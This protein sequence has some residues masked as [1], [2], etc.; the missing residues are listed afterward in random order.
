MNI[1]LKNP[2]TAKLYFTNI[3]SPTAMGDLGRLFRF[4][5]ERRLNSVSGVHFCW[6]FYFRAERSINTQIRQNTGEIPN[7]LEGVSEHFISEWKIITPK[8]NNVNIH[9]NLNTNDT[10][11]LFQRW[12]NYQHNRQQVQHWRQHRHFNQWNKYSLAARHEKTKLNGNREF[13][14]PV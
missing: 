4:T 12:L 11:T 14:E 1:N 2:R 7:M 10:S 6:N 9:W 3:N 8:T 5:N 13:R